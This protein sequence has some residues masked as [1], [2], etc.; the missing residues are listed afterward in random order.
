MHTVLIAT[1]LVANETCTLPRFKHSTLRGALGHGLRRTICIKRKGE[2]ATCSLLKHCPYTTIF[3]NTVTQHEQIPLVC[4]SGDTR[5]QYEPG[6]AIPLQITLM[7]PAM[8]HCAY[9]LLALQEMA[10]QGLGKER[11]KFSL[12]DNPPQPLT[13]ELYSTPFSPGTYRLHLLSPLRSKTG[14]RLTAD[15]AIPKVLQLAQRRLQGLQEYHQQPSPQ[16]L[17][18]LPEAQEI[19]RNLQWLDIGRYSNRQATKMKLG[20]F[21]GTMEFSDPTGAA[22]TMLSAAAKIHIGK[23]TTFGYGKIEL[24][25]I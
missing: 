9:V 4:Y 5:T 23:Q 18:S 22:A 24:E 17:T 10:T 2:C 20:G 8:Q 11:H 19:S 3:D 16:F 25:G 21:V 13:S 14:S 15:L 7:G 12:S 1:N 6:E